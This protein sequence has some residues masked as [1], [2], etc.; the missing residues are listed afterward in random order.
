M[1]KLHFEQLMVG[2]PIIKYWFI[3][4]AF[5]ANLKSYLEKLGAGLAQ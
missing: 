5:V 2:Q 1:E 4:K 3:N